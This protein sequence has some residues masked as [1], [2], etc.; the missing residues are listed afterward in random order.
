MAGPKMTLP[1][2][3]IYRAILIVLVVSVLAG[4]AIALVGEYLLRSDPVS[5]AGAWFAI[6]SGAI[7]FF[8]RWLGRRETRR[9]AAEREERRDPGDDDPQDASGPGH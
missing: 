2:D 3:G 7:Y 9:R 8:F 6:V 5:R 4:V 1:D